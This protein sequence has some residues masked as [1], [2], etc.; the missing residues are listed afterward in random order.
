LQLNNIPK[1]KINLNNIAMKTYYYIILLGFLSSCEILDVSPNTKTDAT[2]VEDTTTTT[3][4]TT[5]QTIP[6][7]TSIIETSGIKVEY[8]YKADVSYGSNNLQNFEIYLPKNQKTKVPV[9]ILLHGGGWSEGDKAFIHPMVQYLQQKNVKCAIVN[10]NYRLTFQSG[11]TYKE[12]L[13][14][15]E[16]IIKKL[17]ANANLYNITPTFFITGISA[18]SHLGMLYAYTSNNT[19]IK[20]VGGIVCPVDLT[21]SQIRQGRMETDITKLVGKPYEEKNIEEYRKASP[22][23][24]ATRN[25]APTILFYGGS[26]ST[27]PKEQGDLINAKLKQLKVTQEFYFYPE[28][29]HNWSKLPETFDKMIVFADK[30]I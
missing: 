1:H 11:I 26:D 19:A 8:D 18:G 29:S 20:A 14:D 13:S 16:S 3:T 21:T 24:Q 15:I 4:P 5:V 22:Y 30:Y 7:Q 27:V 6:T 23:Y 28:Q 10:A 12:Q 25:S 17:Q 9:I 2:I